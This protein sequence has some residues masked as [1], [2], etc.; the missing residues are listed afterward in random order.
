MS[1]V[2]STTDL[3]VAMKNC[4]YFLENSDA[5]KP[6]DETTSE[7]IK[8]LRKRIEEVEYQLSLRAATALAPHKL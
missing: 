6:D 1:Y 3:L 4:I 8:A 2:D 7:L 5:I